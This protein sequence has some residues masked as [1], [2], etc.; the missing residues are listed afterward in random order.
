MV[1]AP[2]TREGDAENP[3]RQRVDLLVIHVKKQF[4]LILLRQ[5]L[6]PKSQKTGSDQ[7][8]AVDRGGLIG[9]EQV[10]RDLFAHE[11]VEGNI[12]VETFDDVI[13]VL[14]CIRVTMVLVVPRGIGISRHVQPVAA[15]LLAVAGRGQ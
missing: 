13:A 7:A 9:R 6:L 12:L 4:L 1:V 14:I 8:A 2:C 3:L 11:A 5:S 15:P 10:A